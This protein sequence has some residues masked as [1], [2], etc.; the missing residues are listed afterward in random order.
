MKTREYMMKTRE[1]M[2]KT[3]EYKMKTREYMMKTREYMM[4]T[5]EYR[6]RNRVRNREY[7]KYD[8]IHVCNRIIYILTVNV[9]LDADSAHPRLIVS[10]DGKQVRYEEKQH[11][12]VKNE[13]K[14]QNNKFDEWFCIVGNE[15]FSSGCF[16]Y[17]VQVKGADWWCVGVTRESAQRKGELYVDTKYGYWTVGL[18]GGQYYAGDVHRLFLSVNPE[19][20]GLFVDYEKGRVSF[21]DVKSMCH[22]HSFTDQSFTETLFPFIHLGSKYFYS[23]VPLIICSDLL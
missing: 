4:K 6:E 2:M 19:K 11:V 23:S 17:E 14:G 9:T 3:R 13:D 16:Y 21:Y 1:Y 10:H 20:I 15:G 12:G 22:I 7:R 8:I 5:R 18:S